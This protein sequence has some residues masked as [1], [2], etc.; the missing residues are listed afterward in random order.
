MIDE[1]FLETLQQTIGPLGLQVR[2]KEENFHTMLRF[3]KNPGTGGYG[4]SVDLAK[5][6]IKLVCLDRYLI[7]KNLQVI[8]DNEFEVDL[9]TVFDIL[10][11]K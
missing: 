4:W 5:A 9:G 6:Y 8:N 1:Q 3:T 7:I 2:M 11:R 10:G